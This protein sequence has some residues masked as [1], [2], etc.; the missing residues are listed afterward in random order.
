MKTRSEITAG[1]LGELYEWIDRKLDR[2]GIETQPEVAARVLELVSDPDTG[3]NDYAAVIK[4]DPALTGKLLR[5]VNSAYF[6]QR[7]PVTN[8]ERATVLLGLERLR[9]I[10]LGFYLS[11]AAAGDASAAISRQVWGQS[12]FRACLACELS[13]G[14]CPEHG[15]EAFIVGL[16]LDCGLPMMAKLAGAPFEKLYTQRM[17]PAKQTRMEYETLALTHVD[18]AATL[19]R[20]WRMPDLLAK[21]IEWHHTPPGETDRDSPIHALHRV[22]YYVGAVQLDDEGE[23]RSAAPMSGAAERVLG[24]DQAELGGVVKR[25]MGEYQATNQLFGEVADAIGDADDLA[26]RVHH[27]LVM[28]IDQAF[29][30]SFQKDAMS[31]PQSFNVGGQDVEVGFDAQGSATAYIVDSRGERIASLT[32]SGNPMEP[33]LFFESLGLEPSGGDDSTE[34]LQYVKRVAA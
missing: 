7:K 22:A 16:M 24:I 32:L 34:L 5:M 13:R 31:I 27:Q 9:A 30:A 2:I 8:L 25:A 4:T 11:R 3:M 23:P 18:I 21:P 26:E 12:V 6:A 19:M 15:A 20:R 17:T 14:A 28:A 1:Q 33:E 10:S 29:E